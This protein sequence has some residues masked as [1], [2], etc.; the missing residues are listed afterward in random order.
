MA[1]PKRTRKPVQKAKKPVTKAAKKPAAK[2]PATT[3]APKKPAKAAPKKA[4]PAKP[5]AKPAAAKPAATKPAAPVPTTAEGPVLSRDRLVQTLVAIAP[6]L[7]GDPM[8][9]NES[10]APFDAAELERYFATADGVTLG[11]LFGE[12]LQGM[13]QSVRYSALHVVRELFRDDKQATITTKP[14]L[15][16]DQGGTIAVVGDLVVEGDLVNDGVLVVT[17][18]LTIG[19]AYIGPP[20]DYS[21]AAVGGT[22]RARDVSTSGEILVGERLEADRVI[23][24]LYNDYSCVL[25]TVKTRALVIDDNFPALGTVEADVQ[26]DGIPSDEQLRSLF[27]AA[28]D[29]LAEDD[30]S[31]IRTLIRS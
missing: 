29:K 31:P 5:A 16:I 4:A 10:N 14:A 2:K 6:R 12:T 22:M 19:G 27:G 26:I 17:G 9:K 21:L 30:E 7:A 13:I 3:A 1:R 8:F 15:Q 24:L 25:P 18:D 23:H 20:F 11:H 28:A